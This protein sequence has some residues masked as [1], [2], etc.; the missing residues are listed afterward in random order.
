MGRDGSS[1][2][3]EGSIGESGHATSPSNGVRLLD[4]ESN[5]SDA[6]RRKGGSHFISHRR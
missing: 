3:G 4:W 6:E 1:L 5:H 2:T